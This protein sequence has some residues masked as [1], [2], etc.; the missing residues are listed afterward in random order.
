MTVC[1]LSPVPLLSHLQGFPEPPPWGPWLWGPSRFPSLPSHHLLPPTPSTPCSPH[2]P[3][4]CGVC[5]LSLEQPS[6]SP[7]SGSESQESRGVAC[8]HDPFP[9][10]VTPDLLRAKMQPEEGNSY[11]PRE[12]RLSQATF[13]P[14]LIS[15]GLA[16]L[17][18][19]SGNL[20]PVPV[21]RAGSL[22][23]SQ[24][25]AGPWDPVYPATRWPGGPSDLLPQ[26]G[27]TRGPRGPGQSLWHREANYHVL[28]SQS[29]GLTPR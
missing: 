22:S 27:G 26:E 16:V 21:L 12:H 25:G 11:V 29:L 7:A 17:G 19:S 5:L 24:V 1:S 10:G 4:A 15:R 13:T 20:K 3:D 14:M 28:G 9:L 2:A 18:P 8:P 23:L 6:P